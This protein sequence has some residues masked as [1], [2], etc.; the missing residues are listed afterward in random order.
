MSPLD[1]DWETWG[2]VI[3]TESAALVRSVPRY[4]R[5]F[6][7]PQADRPLPVAVARRETVQLM[8]G[9]LSEASL[10]VGDPTL[11]TETATT[12][13]FT[14]VGFEGTAAGPDGCS[15]EHAS[16]RGVRR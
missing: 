16:I 10:N 5:S 7:F 12:T 6:A 9:E 15:P 11:A 1:Q 2:L 4:H 13:L 3:T 8:S 14:G